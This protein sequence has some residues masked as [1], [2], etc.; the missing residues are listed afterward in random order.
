[1]SSCV[2]VGRDDW[3]RAWHGA[4]HQHQTTAEQASIIA[5]ALY[6]NP[7]T[8]DGVRPAQATIAAQVGIS[9][10]TVGRAIR[11]AVDDGWFIEVA[12]GRG[13]STTSHYRLANPLLSVIDARDVARAA[14][15]V[16]ARSWSCTDAGA[17]SF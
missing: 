13:R 5:Y 10:S 11:R 1:M 9:V 2:P 14:A 7:A 4:P 8:G 6:A 15:Q 17:T 16:A 12:P 3:L